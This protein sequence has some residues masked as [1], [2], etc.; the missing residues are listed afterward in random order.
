MD[1]LPPVPSVL[2]S[3]RLSA[4]IMF[5]PVIA[6]R[7]PAVEYVRLIDAPLPPL[8][9]VIEFAGA[10]VQLPEV[11]FSVTEPMVTPLTTSWER[12]LL[13]APALLAIET[14]GAFGTLAGLHVALALQLYVPVAVGTNVD[15]AFAEESARAVVRRP[16]RAFEGKLIFINVKRG[17]SFFIVF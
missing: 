15:W 4:K 6:M 13:V 9:K 3:V 10:I 14:P 11:P 7:P 2:V 12:V 16:N 1:P 5:P 8:L 17:Q